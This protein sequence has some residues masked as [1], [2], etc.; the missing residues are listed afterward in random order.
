[1]SVL[2]HLRSLLGT[3]PESSTETGPDA[4]AVGA[5]TLAVGDGV[6]ASFAVV[7]Y[8]AEVGLGW[9]DPL[10]S[11]PGRVDVALYVD[12]VPTDVAAERLRRQRAR[13]ESTARADATRGR[14]DDPEGDAAAEDAADLAQRL[15]RGQGRLFRVGLYLTVHAR[16]L[17]DLD[18]ECRRVRA[19]AASLLL[20]AQPTTFRTLQGWTATLP[21]G[22]DRVKTRRVMD[23]DA[24]AAAFP[25]TSPDLPAT[26]GQTAVLYGQNTAS[27]S[28]VIWDRFGLDNFNSVTLARSGAGKSYLTKLEALR[29]L[30][31]GVEVAVIDPERE[32]ARL[33]D[34]VGGTVVSLGQPGI[35]LNPLDLPA[36]AADQPEHHRDALTRRGLFLHTLPSTPTTASS[37][38]PTATPGP[39]PRG[40]RSTAARSTPP[41]V[42]R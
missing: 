13:L 10:L 28:P 15:A 32:Y 5:R 41:H 36:E 3:A 30:Y 24:A 37:P 14:L 4:I 12:P 26:T 34:A 33:A 27:A 19:L 25:F 20:D 42:W 7:G 40:N 21:L 22:V 8:P 17:K 31:A 39:S 11:D 6:C 1:M 38:I 18:A 23:T 35:R 16:T 9:L 2:N 29:L